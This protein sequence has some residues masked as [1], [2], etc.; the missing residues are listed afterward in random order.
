VLSVLVENRS[1]VLS[2]VANLFSRRG[3]NIVSLAVAPTQDEQFSRIT[4]VVDVE[5][6]PLEQIVKQLDKLVNVVD[7]SELDPR[8]SVERELMLA[9]VAAPPEMR[10]QVVELVQIFEGRILAVTHEELTVSLEGH[11]SKVDDFEEMLRSFGIRDLQRT[12]RVALPRL[13]R[14]PPES[15]V[16]AG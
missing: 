4:V 6:A 13:S 9:T 16:A 5:S 12:G 1:G 7:I 8:Y 2:R 3:Y 10:G 15:A 14:T 11:P